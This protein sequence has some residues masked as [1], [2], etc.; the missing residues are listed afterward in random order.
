M[1][2]KISQGLILIEKEG[3][4]MITKKI[5]LALI[6]LV[7]WVPAAY[8]AD[9]TLTPDGK[10]PGTPFQALQQQIDQLKTQLQNIQLTPG[11]QGP[12]GPAGP[13]GPKGDKGDQ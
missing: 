12:A 9:V 1:I 2:L 3:K 7:L 6:A 4:I 11:P 10:V 5:V 8:A 13:A